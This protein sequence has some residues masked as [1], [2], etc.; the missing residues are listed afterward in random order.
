MPKKNVQDAYRLIEGLQIERLQYELPGRLFHELMPIDIRKMLAAFYTRPQAADLLARLTISSSTETIYDPACGSGTILVSAYRRKLALHQQE[1]LAGN[2]HKRFCEQE[3]FGSDIMPFAVHLTT[4]NL[5]AMDPSTTIDMAQIIRGDSLKLSKGYKYKT[6]IQ[7]TL[8]PAARK[9]YSMKGEDR[10]VDLDKV[11]VVLMNPPFTKV[12][13]GI[14][15]YVDM[16]RFSSICGNEIGLWG[17]FVSMVNEFLEEN[18]VF[19]GVLPI[20][21]L[22][23]RESSKI[24][25]FIL[26]N[27]TLLYVIKSTFNYGFSEWAEYRDV[28]V[29]A[30]K[31]K[32]AKGHKIKFVLLKKDLRSLLPEDIGYIA[33]RIE[34]SESLSSEDLDLESFPIEEL[35]S[36]FDNLMWF[37]GAS[38]LK[39]REKLVSFINNLSNFLQSPSE[40]YFRE[41]YRPVPKGVSS[42][43]FLTRSSD[44]CRL[45]ESFL[46]FDDVDKDSEHIDV[47][48]GLGV[49][50]QI[51]KSALVPTLRTP[52][53]IE[54]MNI[55]A[56]LDY[57]AVT[58]YRMLDKVTSAAGFIKPKKFD[59]KLFWL[60]ISREK[61]KTKTR[62]VISR[63]LNPYSPNLHLLG[64]YSETELSPNNQ[65][66]VIKEENPRVAK[67]FCVVINSILFL[68]QFF[69]LKEE[70]T[71]RRIDIRFYDLK[72][73]KIY[74]NKNT[75][76]KLSRIFDQ[77]ARFRFPSLR[78]QLDTEFDSRYKSFWLRNRKKQKSLFEMDEIVNPS[79]ERL[80]FDKAVCNALNLDLTDNEIR[81]GSITK[82]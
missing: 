72:E 67:A 62:I 61:E 70:S 13:R 28:L 40:D 8:F 78:E 16:G 53:G 23:G 32:P 64:F 35:F 76:A 30:K 1:G 44:P 17:H 60:N 55:T 52:V 2:P 69:L 58:P 73:M 15:N 80:A 56:H 39:N 5:A 49:N 37:C 22:R 19:G 10:D 65:L 75:V 50:Y 29:I 20:S 21:V 74:P 68:S 45:E 12:E 48:T 59:W 81:S 71:G 79:K 36:K 3:I 51:E 63:R 42:F 54:T 38:D 66:N 11:N 77:K 43:L 82:T 46:F 7:L 18:G 4:A 9:G 31:A 14:S 25:D 57:L 47:K 24:R 6:G 34:V 27:W 26:S 33:N 41:G